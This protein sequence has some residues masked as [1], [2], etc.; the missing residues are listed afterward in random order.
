MHVTFWFNKNC[1]FSVIIIPLDH[2]KSSL[3]VIISLLEKKYKNVKFTSALCK[4][5]ADNLKLFSILEIEGHN[6]GADHNREL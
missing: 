3:R 1:K 6:V 5:T 4:E 2:G